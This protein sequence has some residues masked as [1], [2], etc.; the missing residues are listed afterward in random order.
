MINELLYSNE[1]N[2]QFFLYCFAR[3]DLEPLLS[4][5]AMSE[6]AAYSSEATNCPV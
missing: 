3:H 6:S 2:R 4:E 1:M 5:S